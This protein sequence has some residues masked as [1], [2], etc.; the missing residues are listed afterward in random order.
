MATQGM[1]IGA[2]LEHRADDVQREDLTAALSAATEILCAASPGEVQEFLSRLEQNGDIVQDALPDE[3]MLPCIS[4]EEEFDVEWDYAD[5]DEYHE[6]QRYESCLENMSGP[7]EP[8]DA[9]VIRIERLPG[10][11]VAFSLPET[12]GEAYRG[13]TQ[14]GNKALSILSQWARTYAAIAK[15]LQDSNRSSSSLASPEAFLATHEVMSQKEFLSQSRLG[16]ASGTFS[17]YV[18]NAR[19]AWDTGSIPLDRLFK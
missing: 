18:R 14:L 12:G 16:V 8:E 4:G 5:E 2:G 13:V 15:W 10:G 19:L 3:E 9:Y 11:A 1:S 17:K 7:F 6:D